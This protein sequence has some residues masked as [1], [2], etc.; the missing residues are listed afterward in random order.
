MIRY[1]VC[2]PGNG[3]ESCVNVRHRWFL[4]TQPS[5][6]RPRVGLEKAKGIDVLEAGTDGLIQRPDPV[7]RGVEPVPGSSWKD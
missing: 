4:A 6:W 1:R 5:S 3:N 7:A 2:M